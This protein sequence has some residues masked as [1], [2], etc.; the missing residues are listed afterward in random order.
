MVTIDESREPDENA[1]VFGVDV[2]YENAK[3]VLIPVPWEG[4]VSYGA[5]TSGGPSA[6]LRAS[7]QLDL[8]DLDFKKPYQAGIC[9]DPR[10][11]NWPNLFSEGSISVDLVGERVH[12]MVYRRTKE[13]LEDDR[14][15]GVVGGEHSVS[16]GIVKA[17]SEKYS[18]FGILHIDAHH[19]LRKAY[20]GYRYSHAS[21][22]Y[23]VVEDLPSVTK[24]TSLGIRDFCEAEFEFAKSQ[25]GRIQTWYDR[26]LFDSLAGGKSYGEITEEIVKSL[27]QDVYISFDIDGLDPS[28]CS[29]TGTPVPGGLSFNQAVSLLVEVVR[30]GRRIVGFDLCEVAPSKTEGEWNEN[31]GARVLYKLCGALVESNGL[32]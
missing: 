1:G 19:D 20:Q 7:H 17:L 5:G 3:L 9:Y 28:L 21:I 22:M 4:T 29:A 16:Y 11:P 14:F 12:E 26:D 23:N 25:K 18:D 6:I 13:I 2:S 8:F 15:V 10:V 31:V 30:S 27:P 24:L 32:V